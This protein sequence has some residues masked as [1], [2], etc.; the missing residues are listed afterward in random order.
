MTAAAGEGGELRPGG[1]VLRGVERRVFEAVAAAVVGAPVGSA[2]CDAAGPLIGALGAADRAMLRGL[3]R[4]LELAPVFSTGRRFSALPREAAERHLR[5]WA[6]SRLPQRRQGVGALRSLALLAHYG[7]EPGWGAVD[8][9]GPWLGRKEVPVLPAP[10]LGMAP[11]G[12]LRVPRPRPATGIPPG[13]AQGREVTND[14]RLRA[15]VCVIGTGAGGAA[16]LARLA[17]MG[18]TA[19]GVEA[20]PYTRAEEFTQ[21]ELEMLP[22]LYQEAG[23]RTT[24]DQAIGILQGRGVGGSTLHNTGLVFAPPAG[25][26]ERWRRDHG[27][28][29]GEEEMERRVAQVLSALR[30]TP[31]PAERING[32]NEALRRGADA[33]GWRYRLALHNREEC[34]ACGYCML[35]CAYNRKYNS[36]LT[37]LPRAVAAGASILADATVLRVEGRAGQRRVVCQL[38]GADRRPTGRVAMIEAP[39]VVVAAGALDSPALLLRS[40]VRGPRVGRGLRLHPAAPLSALFEEP[41]VAWRGLPQSVIVEEFAS[42][43]EDGHGG[44]LFLPSASNWPGLSALL[45]AG[46]GSAHRARMLQLPHL[47]SASVL[48]HDET[49]GR[50]SAGAGTRP[51][52]RY[53]P[54]RRD[55]DELVRGIAALARLYLAA[56]AERVYLPFAGAPPVR[57][58]SELRS[59]L[60][61]ARVE[62][63]RCTLNSVHP[64]GTLAMGSDREHGA[65]S[66]RGEVWDQPGL[67]VADTS[68]FPTSVGVPPQV[69]TMALALGVAEAAAEALP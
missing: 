18:V 40:G 37:F 69:T 47:A 55:R 27:F 51:A 33:L 36:A 26:L 13:L 43:Q 11:G 66:P 63:Y 62:R 3:L 38:L 31:I 58:E 65:V 5:G 39:V 32:N 49:E 2:V 57:S 14:L 44:W 21:R 4:A 60:A 7:D 59:T 64:Q 45:L 28:D 61:S 52:A 22:H 20:G 50:V 10:D 48:L 6:E 35:G 53:W 54:D 12:T 34:S 41:V 17:E 24:G 9:R 8:Y 15:E 68:L 46:F 42:F 16:A 30:A 19:I 56:G 1:F 29:V 25:I 67:F 23:L